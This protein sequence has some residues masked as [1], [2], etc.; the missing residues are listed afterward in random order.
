MWDLDAVSPPVLVD[1]KGKDGKMIPGVLHAGKTGHIYVHDR[2]DC[3]L[4]VTTPP[5]QSRQ[6][7]GAFLNWCAESSDLDRERR[8]TRSKCFKGLGLILTTGRVSYVHVPTSV[9]ERERAID[10]CT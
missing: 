3:S 4:E 9:A 6:S 7:R 1:V 10:R 8:T 2:K 5:R